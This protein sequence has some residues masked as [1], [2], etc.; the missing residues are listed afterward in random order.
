LFLGIAKSVFGKI[1]LWSA[2]C[3]RGPAFKK[4]G[5][6]LLKDVEELKLQWLTFNVKTF[7][8]WGGWISEK[9]QSLTR[10][11]LWIYG[12]LMVI[13]DVPPFVE[14]ER[15]TVDQWYKEDYKKWLKVRGEPTEGDKDLLKERVMNFLK[16]PVVQQPQFL[17]MECGSADG[18]M[19]MLRCMVVMFTTLMQPAIEGEKH[20]KMIALRVRLCLNAVVEF[21]ANMK[22]K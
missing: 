14:P 1:S 21:E 7:D 4:V 5:I 15:C 8:S 22:K 19:R 2:R 18:M 3:G 6:N 20:A 10:I 17:P 9:F 16:L 13:D 12:G 11:A